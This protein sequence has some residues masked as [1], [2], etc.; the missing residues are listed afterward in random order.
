[1]YVHSKKKA[2]LSSISVEGGSQETAFVSLRRVDGTPKKTL[3][4]SREFSSLALKKRCSSPRGESR[5]APKN[6]V[7]VLEKCRGWHSRNCVPLLEKRRGWHPRNSVPEIQMSR[8]GQKNRVPVLENGRNW[9]SRKGVPVLEKS[10]VWHSRNCV[11]V[12][13]K[14]RGCYPKW[15]SPPREVS[16][17][18]PKKQRSCPRGDSKL[19]SRNGVSIFQNYLGWH[20]RTGVNFLEKSRG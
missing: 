11:P 17:V 10:R 8:G 15:N 3:P 13:E 1:M 14:S 12:I 4:S 2:S 7:P 18:A 20:S 9:H 5:V 6:C 19:C 16:S